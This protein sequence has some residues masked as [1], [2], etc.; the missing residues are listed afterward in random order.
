MFWSPSLAGIHAA[1]LASSH[2]TVE[3]PL[4]EAEIRGERVFVKAECL[5]RTGSF[6]LR[7]A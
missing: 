5:Q 6:K 4:I 3:T 2:V 7:G 1:A